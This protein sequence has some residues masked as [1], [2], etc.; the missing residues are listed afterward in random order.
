MM[1]TRKQTLNSYIR[2]I[3]QILQIQSKICHM[4]HYHVNMTKFVTGLVEIVHFFSIITNF[5]VQAMQSSSFQ[6]HLSLFVPNFT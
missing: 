6:I 4:F 1:L 5:N 3:I 2:G